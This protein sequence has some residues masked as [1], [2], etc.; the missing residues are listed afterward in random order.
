M[1]LALDTHRQFPTIIPA[2]KS[3]FLSFTPTEIQVANLIK[4]GKR[5]KEIASFMH[6]SESAID[7]HRHNIRKKLESVNKK[8]NLRSYLQSL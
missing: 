6:I 4:E 1:R 2:K 7:F 3:E 5:T 8:I